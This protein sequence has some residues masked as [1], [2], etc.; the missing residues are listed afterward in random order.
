MLKNPN[1]AAADLFSAEVVEKAISAMRGNSLQVPTPAELRQRI[2]AVYRTLYARI[3]RKAASDGFA[4]YGLDAGLREADQ[5][6]GML[7]VKKEHHGIHT[8]MLRY[9]WIVRDYVGFE[10]RR[11]HSNSDLL[12]ILFTDHLQLDPKAVAKV[13]KAS[14]KH[15]SRMRKEEDTKNKE[16]RK[17][18]EKAG[19]PVRALVDM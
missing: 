15:I 8:E 6:K 14:R 4:R 19:V 12:S 17:G 1:T 13:E 7:K 18:L 3:T 5:E 11:L 10:N 2:F 16:L 9:N